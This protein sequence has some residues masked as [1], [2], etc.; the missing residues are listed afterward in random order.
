[1]T[2]EK[3]L[4]QVQDKHIILQPRGDCIGTW[5]PNTCIPLTTRRAI[6]KHKSE[7]L[8]RIA[9]SDIRTCPSRDLHRQYYRYAGQGRFVCGMCALLEKEVTRL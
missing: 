1:M 9:Q 5:A 3:L 4:D 8:H 2:L 7:L 6:W